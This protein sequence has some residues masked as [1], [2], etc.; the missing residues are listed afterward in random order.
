[1]ENKEV[2]KH[3]DIKVVVIPPYTMKGRKSFYVYR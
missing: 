2:Y 1:M 3:N